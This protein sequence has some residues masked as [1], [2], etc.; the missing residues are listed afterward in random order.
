MKKL[1]ALL[2]VM[3]LLYS[4]ISQDCPPGG[5]ALFKTQAQ[6]DRFRFDYPDCTHLESGL[7]IG[8]GNMTD[9]RNLDGLS[10]ITSVD[11][12]ILILYN[13][14]LK[15]LDGLNNLQ[16]IGG[17]IYI[18]YNFSLKS[19][20]ALS[21]L[22][23]IGGSISICDSPFLTSLSG[24]ENIDAGTITDV[25]FFRNNSLTNCSVKSICD[26][27]KGSNA[28]N[29]F[30]YNTTGC[31]CREEVDSACN[32]ISVQDLDF[33]SALTIYPNPVSTNIIIG[34]P[35]NKALKSTF[36]AIY[37]LNGQPLITRRMMEPVTVV[38]VSGWVSGVY[39]VK[40]TDNKS[41]MVGKFVKQ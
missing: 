30:Y 35:S 21:S 20:E 11:F 24:L 12:D 5:G 16:S 34:I 33:N 13:P 15:D 31:N 37:N 7:C 1:L 39:F 36:L 26:F 19:L 28:Q 25:E 22:T 27:L 23:S 14:N 32:L 18:H 40:V 4:G 10:N 6:V 17:N 9:I 41:V 8:F 2:T 3:F 38:D 29:L